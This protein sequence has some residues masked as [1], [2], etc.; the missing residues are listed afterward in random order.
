M[1]EIQTKLQSLNRIVKEARTVVEQKENEL[2]D[3]CQK[4]SKS[5]KKTF[6]K[7][8]KIYKIIDLEKAIYY[9]HDHIDITKHKS[10][11][12]FFKPTN[13]R[14]DPSREHH[15]L[16]KGF[17]VIGSVYN[18][19]NLLIKEGVIVLIDYLNVKEPIKKN[20]LSKTKVY[21]MIDKNTGFYKIGRSKTPLKRERTLQ[22]EKPT[23]E[24][25]FNY[26]AINKDEKELHDIFKGKRIRGEWF[27]LSGSDLSFI[28]D[29]FNNKR[30]I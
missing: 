26:D 29:Y 27:D 25:L 3:W 23:I 15:H 18:D 1:N 16:N 6:P 4:N 11:G 20:P 24:M 7:L 12:Y 10:D 19:D 21:V 17:T 5:I 22:S 14:F 28:R 13:V 30:D 9:N 8:E 2:I